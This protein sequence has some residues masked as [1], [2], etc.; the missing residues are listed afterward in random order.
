M[1]T[2]PPDWKSGAS[3]VEPA[4][5]APLQRQEEK[6]QIP[7]DKVGTF[8]RFARDDNESEDGETSSPLQRQVAAYWRKIFSFFRIMSQ[9]A[10]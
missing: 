4:S 2:P 3:T 1:S 9:M 6:Q 5:E 10:K 7:S 8:G